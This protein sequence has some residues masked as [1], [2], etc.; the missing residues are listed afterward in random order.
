MR[1]LY[2]PLLLLVFASLGSGAPPALPEELRSTYQDLQ[3]R[4]E[5]TRHEF[6][7]I[8]Q[9][10]ERLVELRRAGRDTPFDSLQFAT[11][12]KRTAGHLNQVATGLL[13]VLHRPPMGVRGEV[14][15]LLLEALGRMSEAETWRRALADA[16][17]HR[18]E[19][20]E[21][22]EHPDRRVR[23]A[24]VREARRMGEVA[25][26]AFVALRGGGR[27][28][29]AAVVRLHDAKQRERDDLV[30]PPEES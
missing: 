3:A 10:H 13:G 8:E 21:Q 9:L 26:R 19:L 5:G 12:F 25:G 29:I 18:R 27:V 6:L 1:S 22:L 17:E 28:G 4:L 11:A 15:P 23:D 24:A 30:P 14:A 2:A 7:R 16:S 20:T